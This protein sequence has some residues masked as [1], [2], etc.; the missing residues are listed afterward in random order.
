MTTSLRV[1]GIPNVLA[2][3]DFDMVRKRFDF[4]LA[5][6]ALRR[7]GE[8]CYQRQ[9]AASLADGGQCGPEVARLLR[10]I[11]EVQSTPLQFPHLGEQV[12]ALG[13]LLHLPR[14]D[15]GDR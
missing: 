9:V 2:D 3:R 10:L 14:L 6:D 5:H 13:N 8:A 7:R 12:K 1:G 15:Q 11:E 4:V